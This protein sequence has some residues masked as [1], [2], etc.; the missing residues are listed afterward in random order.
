MRRG[1]KAVRKAELETTFQGLRSAFNVEL[2]RLVKQDIDKWVKSFEE[3][4]DIQQ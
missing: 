1:F 3:F 4:L 2:D